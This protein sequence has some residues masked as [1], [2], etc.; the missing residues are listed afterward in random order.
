MLSLPE[1]DDDLVAIR[2]LTMAIRERM[3]EHGRARGGVGRIV[4]S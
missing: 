3:L 4:A 1:T 2:D